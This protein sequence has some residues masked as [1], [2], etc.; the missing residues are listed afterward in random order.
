MPAS[1]DRQ[2]HRADAEP[3]GADD[4]SLIARSR[5]EPA[6]FAEIFRRYG[7]EIQRYVVRR[8][9]S[10]PAD[11]VVAETF[12]A[13]FRQR[14]SYDVGRADARPWLYGI[15]SHLISRHRRAEIRGYRLLARTGTDPVT[16]PFTDQV[17][18]AVSA[19][20][21][22]RPLAVALAALPAGQRDALLLVT[23]SELSYAQA[24]EAL[25]VPIGTVRSRVNR[26]RE[27]LRR[28]LRDVAPPILDEEFMS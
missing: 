16:A 7:P 1:Q 10:G 23:W 6:Q 20:S 26:A 17:D 27:R 8:L 18:A 4:A 13:A 2:A 19:A 22:R 3:A 25:G 14:D 12:L 11:D 24:A 5:E 9:G 28:A 15:A 21:A